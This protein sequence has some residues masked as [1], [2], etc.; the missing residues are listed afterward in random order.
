MLAL[1]NGVRVLMKLVQC[2]LLSLMWAALPVQASTNQTSAPVIAYL[3]KLVDFKRALSEAARS[4][5]SA[6]PEVQAFARQVVD[7]IDIDELVRKESS[8]INTLL[9]PEQAT[10]CLAFVA[11]SLADKAASVVRTSATPE[12][13]AV[14]LESL[15]SSDRLKI[16]GFFGSDCFEKARAALKSPEFQRAA[17][18]YGESLACQYLELNNPQALKVVRSKGSCSSSTE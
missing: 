3:F 4:Q 18:S 7:L 9:P 6:D 13:A 10:T 16:E 15:S 12:E 1:T 5:T 11:S 2:L 8:L 14:A 17:K